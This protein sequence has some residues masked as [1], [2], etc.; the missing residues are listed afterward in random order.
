MEK[1]L[2][3]K[4]WYCRIA[5]RMNIT[6]CFVNLNDYSI[7]LLCFIVII[8]LITVLGLF[9]A[10]APVLATTRLS[11]KLIIM[12][13]SIC[14]SMWFNRAL[15]CCDYGYN[16]ACHSTK[17]IFLFS[18]LMDCNFVVD[19]IFIIGPTLVIIFQH[20][21]LLDSLYIY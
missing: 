8:T 19:V 14:F 6:L 3:Q 9:F 15:Q 17:N 12:Y 18:M 2:F 20:I 21:F 5:I 7:F 16:C 11:L 1:I 4:I 10:F 13:L